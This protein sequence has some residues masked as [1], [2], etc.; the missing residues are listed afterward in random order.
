MMSSPGRDA[1][2]AQDQPGELW[3]SRPPLCESGGPIAMTV[4]HARTCTECTPANDITMRRAIVRFSVGKETC[5]I[6]VY[7][8]C[9]VLPGWVAVERGRQRGWQRP[10]LGWLCSAAGSVSSRP[11]GVLSQPCPLSGLQPTHSPG[12]TRS[13]SSPS[14]VW[15]QTHK[16]TIYEMLL[17]YNSAQLYIVMTYWLSGSILKLHSWSFICHSISLTW[18]GSQLPLWLPWRCGQR[19]PSRWTGNA[20]EPPCVAAGVPRPDGMDVGGPR[21]TVTEV[22]WKTVTQVSYMTWS[23]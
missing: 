11:A 13:L 16:H 22:L 4:S 12:R 23:M 10:Y 20:P 14:L 5:C 9:V 8:L 1:W 21:E 17:T 18:M 19:T 7:I 2:R 6:F 3:K 15:R